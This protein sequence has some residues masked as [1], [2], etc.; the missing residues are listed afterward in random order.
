[1]GV[2]SLLSFPYLNFN[3]EF[4]NT[5]IS[6]M[7]TIAEIANTVSSHCQFI[8]SGG[9]EGSSYN[10]ALGQ[11]DLNEQLVV[12]TTII[13][14]LPF[15]SFALVT[16]TSPPNPDFTSW[17]V[18]FTAYV[19]DMAPGG[20]TSGSFVTSADY[21]TPR[22]ILGL[23][24]TVNGQTTDAFGDPLP[25]FT[26]NVFG[27]Q[28]IQTNGPSG[29][30]TT[31]PS[32][33][34]T[35]NYDSGFLFV[36]RQHLMSKTVFSTQFTGS[37]TSATFNVSPNPSQ[38]SVAGIEG[39]CIS[40]SLPLSMNVS[41]TQVL[42]TNGRTAVIPFKGNSVT[43]LVANRYIEVNKSY[44]SPINTVLSFNSQLYNAYTSG[45]PLTGFSSNFYVDMTVI[46]TVGGFSAPGLGEVYSNVYLVA[47]WIGIVDNGEGNFQTSIYSTLVDSYIGSF[48]NESNA[49]SNI[50]LKLSGTAICPVT[51]KTTSGGADLKWQLLGVRVAQVVGGTQNPS[52][53]LT[54]ATFNMTLT[55]PVPDPTTLNQ[56]WSLFTGLSP[57]LSFQI[58]RHMQFWCVPNASSAT[59]L[60]SSSRRALS[61]NIRL[62]AQELLSRVYGGNSQT[63]LFTDET[64]RAMM[65]SIRDPYC[66]SRMLSYVNTGDHLFQHVK[67]SDQRDKQ[68][69]PPEVFTLNA[70]PRDILNFLHKNARRISK[71]FDKAMGLAERAIP[72]AERVAPLLASGSH[73]R[74]PMMTAQSSYA[75]GR[76]S[77]Y[78]AGRPQLYSAGQTSLPGMYCAPSEGIMGWSNSPSVSKVIGAASN[79]CKLHI[80]PGHVHHKGLAKLV[81]MA[82]SPTECHL[83]MNSG[84]TQPQ[85]EVVIKQML[86]PHESYARIMFSSSHSMP[87]V[88]KVEA[89]DFDEYGSDDD[90]EAP[91]AL[92]E[93]EQQPMPEMEAP[94]LPAAVYQP[95]VSHEQPVLPLQVSR[96]DSLNAA[97]KA[98][99]I[100]SESGLVGVDARW[101][102]ELSV[103]QSSMVF[104]KITSAATKH[105]SNLRSNICAPIPTIGSAIFIAVIPDEDQSV[106]T[107]SVSVAVMNIVATTTTLGSD[108]GLI[109]TTEV[110]SGLTVKVSTQ[111]RLDEEARSQ[112]QAVVERF[113]QFHKGQTT[114]PIISI[115]VTGVVAIP[116]ESIRGPSWGLALLC[117]LL[118]VPSGVPMTGQWDTN[119][120]DPLDP[121]A[122]EIQSVG[123]TF[124]KAELVSHGRPILVPLLDF[125]EQLALVSDPS[126]QTMYRVAANNADLCVN[127][128]GDLVEF[129]SAIFR[130]KSLFSVLDILSSRGF[131]SFGL[132]P[133]I[134]QLIGSHGVRTLK[135]VAEGIP[136]GKSE[137]E[138][139][140]RKCSE[141]AQMLSR[142]RGVITLRS[143]DGDLV[144]VSESVLKCINKHDRKAMDLLSAEVKGSVHHINVNGST[145]Y[146]FEIAEIHHQPS[147]KH[148][149]VSE[150]ANESFKDQF[151]A[152]KDASAALTNK[153]S[154]YRKSLNF[155]L[156]DSSVQ[157]P[158]TTEMISGLSKRVGE[159]SACA[160]MSRK[161]K[162]RLGIIE[163]PNTHLKH[164]FFYPELFDSGIV[165]KAKQSQTLAP[166]ALEPSTSGG[167]SQ[168][169][170]ILQAL[171]GRTS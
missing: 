52:F 101:E 86:E 59:L 123:L 25:P 103:D 161:Y 39:S 15:T 118:G 54:T 8:V 100:L 83:I 136:S 4:S 89:D 149:P 139:I 12:Q 135:Q 37:I 79:G 34:L 168:K 133:S 63:C 6:T 164:Y 147:V 162:G 58:D 108:A 138:R 81:R 29:M 50:T 20:I 21:D 77:I 91:S 68:G 31:D 106:G 7:T 142:D 3:H 97:E 140:K 119:T 95:V 134:K 112:F 28:P 5:T 121:K 67:S 13:E 153:I 99:T 159:D 1:M 82:A 156:K 66:F 64:F 128:L 27:L 55:I 84:C 24:T 105:V 165:P 22:D 47:D 43:P 46:Y 126:I 151:K 51:P 45:S 56:T 166:L 41:E 144:K 160:Q 116:N 65:E 9:A 98:M 92:F 104:T 94:S 93:E 150:S 96:M 115:F 74:S 120:F 114:F 90:F 129:N 137:M 17:V 130:A 169:Q 171:T 30:I 14:N 75:A 48:F 76:P 143:V 170:S 32:I 107:N 35:L 132:M 78:G 44:G 145:W 158:I 163:D 11:E 148:T 109:F 72:L 23:Y 131:A 87:P 33:V 102:A 85:D 69:H 38:Q 73:L 122:F 141:I 152:A 2:G 42:V 113:L 167:L 60:N 70:A 57:N 19:S 36:S 40:G 62:A 18:A 117:A 10:P 155:E 80:T 154:K 127:A 157:V 71:G 125:E 110:F 124:A 16:M 88:F 26:Q 61:Q 49:P 146:W 53:S 111:F